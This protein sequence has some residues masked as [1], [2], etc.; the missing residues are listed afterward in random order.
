MD[1]AAARTR[2]R[3]VRFAEPP[4][5]G[6]G[7]DGPRERRR[8]ERGR[9]SRRRREPDDRGF[10]SRGIA[11]AVPFNRRSIATSPRVLVETT[12]VVRR[13]VRSTARRRVPSKT[14]ASDGQA[15]VPQVPP[16]SRG[17]RR[18]ERAGGGG[19]RRRRRRR[20]GGG[21][22]SRRASG[23]GPRRRQFL[24]ARPTV[25]RRGPR[26]AAY[27]SR[28]REHPRG[29]ARSSLLRRR[30]SV[31][32]A[33]DP[34]T[35]R[36]CCRFAARGRASP[37][38]LRGGRSPPE[39]PA[40]RN[41]TRPLRVVP[42]D[43]HVAADGVPLLAERQ[44]GGGACAA[45]VSGR[46]ASGPDE[47]FATPRAGSPRLAVSTW[48]EL[49]EAGRRSVARVRAYEGAA[50]ASVPGKIPAHERYQHYKMMGFGGMGAKTSWAR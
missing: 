22:A 43:R 3:V 21:D 5:F 11:R 16:R 32:G 36:V 25:L 44:P 42:D 26:A 28:L 1:R 24:P 13:L 35:S 34:R 20:V 2:A 47:P 31:G 7:R 30:A 14:D 8:G 46:S 48:H 10:A 12:S 15:S 49:R 29:G 9:G 39:A 27:A 6:S 50:T 37:P 40:P 4:G 18:R 17:S 38:L 41:E 33:F 23:L 19:G 45:G